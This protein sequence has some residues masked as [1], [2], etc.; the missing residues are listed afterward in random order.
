MEE[1][2]SVDDF[3]T[4]VTRLV[5]Q[6]KMHREKMKKYSKINGTWTWVVHHT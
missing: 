3:F 2:E 6:I 5:N 1:S 4:K